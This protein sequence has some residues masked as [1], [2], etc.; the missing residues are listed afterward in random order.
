MGVKGVETLGSEIRSSSVLDIF[1]SLLPRNNVDI[2][3]SSTAQTTAPT[4]HWIEGPGY[5]RFNARCE[6]LKEKF[7]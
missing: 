3:I 4:Q 2:T 5:Q 1:F 6:I 7:I